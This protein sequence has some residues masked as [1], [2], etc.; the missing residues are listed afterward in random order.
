M[1]SIYQGRIN[2]WRCSC[3]HINQYSKYHFTKSVWGPSVRSHQLVVHNNT[4][5]TRKV[6]DNES[7]LSECHN[8]TLTASWLL[9]LKFINTLLM[10]FPLHDHSLFDIQSWFINSSIHRKTT[11][12]ASCKNQGCISVFDT[13]RKDAT[14]ITQQRVSFV[15]QLWLQINFFYFLL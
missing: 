4:D 3:R 14:R 12:V 8:L 9:S 5:Q 10:S 1:S 13:Y 7:L 6:S 11:G 2:N 15:V